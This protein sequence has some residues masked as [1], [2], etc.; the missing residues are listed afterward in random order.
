MRVVRV[1]VES[2]AVGVQKLERLLDRRYKVVS[3]GHGEVRLDDDA[4][5][6]RRRVRVVEEVVRLLR[7][8]VPA[9]NAETMILAR[10]ATA[11]VSLF[12]FLAIVCKIARVAGSSDAVVDCFDTRVVQASAHVSARRFTS[13]WPPGSQIG[14]ACAIFPRATPLHIVVLSSCCVVAATPRIQREVAPCGRP[15]ARVGSSGP[16]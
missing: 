4:E 9:W 6:G 8:R 13:Q 2:R 16:R 1:R 7:D 10:L 11:G 14:F 3:H 5:H 15:R 12:L